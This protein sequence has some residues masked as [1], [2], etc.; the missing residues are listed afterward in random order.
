MHALAIKRLLVDLFVEEHARAPKQIILYL[1]ATR[2]RRS[3]AAHPRLD[4]SSEKSSRGRGGPAWP[5]SG[6]SAKW[7]DSARCTGGPMDDLAAAAIRE[8]SV[9]VPPSQHRRS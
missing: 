3:S 6:S 2:P 9:V 7:H 4:P 8:C 1:D 5:A